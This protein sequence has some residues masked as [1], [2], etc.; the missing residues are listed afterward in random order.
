MSSSA[1]DMLIKRL[2][3]QFRRGLTHI[4]DKRLNAGV[5]PGVCE[6]HVF[7]NYSL[8]IRI[9]RLRQASAISAGALVKGG[10]SAFNLLRNGRVTDTHFAHAVVHVRHERLDGALRQI[11]FCGPL[12]IETFE[13]QKEV[14]RNHLET[15]FGCVRNAHVLVK[16]RLPRRGHDAAIKLL[17]SAPRFD[18]SSEP[19]Q[20]AFKGPSGDRPPIKCLGI[21]QG[22]H[23][24]SLLPA[25]DAQSRPHTRKSEVILVV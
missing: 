7:P 21:A 17:R 9:F 23:D 16:G 4:S 20:H 10:G 3:R 24:G 8:E 14:Q 2:G 13:R 12:P 19:L 6:K 22:G 1:Y 25:I 11:E 5:V 18:P 15:P